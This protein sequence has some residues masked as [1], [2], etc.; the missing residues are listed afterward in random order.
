MT[1]VISKKKSGD[2]VAD[3]QRL[4]EETSLH[5]KQ[6]IG[7]LVEQHAAELAALFYRNM[8]AD[9]EANMFLDHD[10]VNQRLHASMQRWLLGLF[11]VET[12]DPQTI[13]EYQCKV[14]EVHARI[15]IPFVLVMRGARLLKQA[16]FGYLVESHLERNDL[17]MATNYISEAMELALD[18]MIDYFVINMEKH[19]RADEGYRL[20]SLGQNMIAERERQ[21]AALL[22]WA[23]QILMSLLADGDG[24]GLPD[25]QHSEFGMWLKHKATIIFESAPELERI[26]QRIEEVE[27]TILPKMLA[28][29]RGSGDARLLMKEIEVGI[30]EIKFLLG[31]LFDR[32]IEMEGGRDSLTHLLNRRFLPVVLTRELNLAR[33][34]NESFAVM[35]ID[36]DHFKRINDTFGHAGG[37]L[38]LQQ[39]SDIIVGSV[40][41][42][43]F[44]FRY[45]G[46]EMLVVLVEIDKDQAL[47]VAENIRKKFASELLRVGENQTHGITV[48]IGVAAY[49]GHPD[50]ETM[51]NDADGALYRAKENGRN[52]CVVSD[53]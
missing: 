13:Y 46:E 33:R 30:T 15:Q 20:F 8:L 50:F 36:L 3:W 27:K 44:V 35:L 52:C 48:S 4:S 18:A 19:A 31:G 7:A 17:V 49:S 32:F 11:S 34:L 42:G 22:E 21:R 47:L 10:L 9:P 12:Q 16:I 1:M 39:A 24:G 45:G 53:R 5:V 29:R 37:D 28:A 43:D 26:R 51:I 38:V 41:A 14:G 6:A 25:I 40:R 23:Q 2:F